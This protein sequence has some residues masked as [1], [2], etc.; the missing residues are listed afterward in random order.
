VNAQTDPF[1]A[2]TDQAEG[3]DVPEGDLAEYLPP[4]AAGLTM[5]AGRALAQLEYRDAQRWGERPL[6]RTDDD[7]RGTVLALMPPACDAQGADFRWRAAR[8]FWDLADDLAADRAP[9][10]RCAAESWALQVML[11]HAPKICAATDAELRMWGVP[12]PDGDDGDY[13]PPDFEDQPFMLLI[14]DAENSIPEARQAAHPREPA[15][16]DGAVPEGGWSGP[17]YWFSP[18]GLTVPRDPDALNDDESTSGTLAAIL[19]PQAADLLAAAADH[20]A[21]SGWPWCRRWRT[22]PAICADAGHRSRRAPRR[23]SPST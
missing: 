2:L 4:F 9:L 14:E 16:E 7:A 13:Y 21:D 15:E 6:V 5:V 22:S 17:R 20:V 11:E 10:A 1:G 18:Y 19:T 3:F 8:A 12:V 23:N